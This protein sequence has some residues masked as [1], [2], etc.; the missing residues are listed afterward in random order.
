[1]LVPSGPGLS[2]DLPNKAVY[3]DAVLQADIIIPDSGLMVLLWN[4]LN[5]NRSHVRIARYSGLRLLRDLL[6]QPE[7]RTEGASYWIMPDQVEID[8]TVAWLRRAGYADLSEEDCYLAPFYRDQLNAD[9]GVEDAV[10]LAKLEER[11]PAYIFVNVGSGSRNSSA[12]ICGS[13][14]LTSRRSFARARPSRFSPAVRHRSRRGRIGST[15]GGCCEFFGTR[16][17]SGDVI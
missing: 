3:R 15:S 8:R 2:A 10:L 5:L 9:G 17:D 11:R 1:M 12:G 4:L 7:V 6:P 16:G 13:T 14:C